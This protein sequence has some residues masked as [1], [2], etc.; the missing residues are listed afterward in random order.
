LRRQEILFLKWKKR[1]CWHLV[2]ETMLIFG[3][4]YIGN[5]LAYS[6]EILRF[7]KVWMSPARINSPMDIIH[8]LEVY[9]PDVVINC[10]GRTGTPNVDWCENHKA[11]TLFANVTIPSMLAIE[12]S[13]YKED[14]RGGTPLVHIGSGCVYENTYGKKTETDAPNFYGSY[15]SRTKIMAQTILSEFPNVLQLRIRMPIGTKPHPKNLLNKLI[16]FDKVIDLPNSVTTLPT[17]E[18]V[19]VELLRMGERGIYNVVENG[20]ITHPEII[21]IYNRIALEHHLRLSYPE[22]RIMSL[23]EMYGLVKT[24][25]SNCILSVRK[26]QDKGIN[27]PLAEKAIEYCIEKLVK[28]RAKKLLIQHNSG[29]KYE[30]ND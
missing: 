7:Y 2:K 27:I 1:G 18:K 15:Y 19:L 5:E 13:Q 20:P 28:T 29:E 21:K 25:R 3:N 24:P 6:E 9:K 8:E 12:C 4:G 16:Q 17:L 10:I 26:L 14:E 23:T 30:H 11:E 22:P